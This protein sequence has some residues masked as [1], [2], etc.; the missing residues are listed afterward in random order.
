L[1]N[2]SS[3][4]ESHQRQHPR[5][6]YSAL[7]PFQAFLTLLRLWTRQIQRGP[8][9]PPV[10]HSRT[11]HSRPHPRLYIPTSSPPLCLTIPLLDLISQHLARLCF[12]F[13]A[14]A[15]TSMLGWARDTG[16]GGRRSGCRSSGQCWIGERLARHMWSGSQTPRPSCRV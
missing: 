8:Y 9:T 11:S 4:L 13:S 12:P 16:F 6:D 7:P 3:L 14:L 10:Q 1:V 2:I 15:Y 5:M